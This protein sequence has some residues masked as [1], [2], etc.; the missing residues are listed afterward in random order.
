M[1]KKSS[2]K[3]IGIL[4]DLIELLIY[5][6]IAIWAFND[7]PKREKKPKTTAPTIDLSTLSPVAKY[8]YIINE[9]F[10]KIF[11]K[12]PFF[13]A[14][15]A[16]LPVIKII[17]TIDN[18][19]N[20]EFVGFALSLFVLMIIFIL[21]IIV[22]SCSVKDI[23]EAR[24]EYHENA[25]PEELANSTIELKTIKNLALIVMIYSAIFFV[26][27]FLVYVYKLG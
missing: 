9:S 2:S 26:I 4:F 24:N 25:S 3:D 6:G 1:A 5:S 13:T 14:L 16:T 20:D 10:L 18:L 11:F 27:S 15:T 8:K 7:K 21:D 12:V 22:I 17:H 19:Y 23:L